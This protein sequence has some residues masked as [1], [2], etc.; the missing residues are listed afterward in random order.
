MHEIIGA[1]IAVVVAIV[2]GAWRLSAVIGTNH[3]G[4]TRSLN[5]QRLEFTQ[6]FGEMAVRIADLKQGPCGDEGTRGTTREKNR[7]DVGL[8]D[9]LD[10][11]GMLSGAPRDAIVKGMHPRIKPAPEAGTAGRN[12]AEG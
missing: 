6:K 9:S 1:A 5:D 4:L 10:R 2:G 12:H 3:A 8:V 7:P 11:D